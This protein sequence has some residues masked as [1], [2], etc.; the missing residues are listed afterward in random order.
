MS[1]FAFHNDPMYVLL[2]APLEDSQMHPKLFASVLFL[3]LV[4]V[5]SHRAHAAKLPPL[6]HI[7]SSNGVVYIF[8]S[9]RVS[10][11]Y[12]TEATSIGT[13]NEVVG[14]ENEPRNIRANRRPE[15]MQVWGIGPVPILIDDTADH[16]LKALRMDSQFISLHTITGGEH[17]LY[18]RATT[19]TLIEAPDTRDVDPRV[20]S[21]IYPGPPLV[22]TGQTLPWQVFET[23]QE[24]EKLI[25]EKRAQQEAP[26]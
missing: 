7:K 10:A 22:V 8:D 1:A 21:F 15:K 4:S 11:I 3:A 20:K 13:E 2:E 14:T 26:E 12:L 25:N 23:P 9:A 5:A 16:F 17:L 6:A 19:V 24:V 18:L